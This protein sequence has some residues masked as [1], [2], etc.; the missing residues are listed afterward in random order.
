MFQDNEHFKLLNQHIEAGHAMKGL[1]FTIY[2]DNMRDTAIALF[3]L[4]QN[5]EEQNIKIIKEWA[6]KNI[7]KDIIEYA[8]RLASLHR[9]DDAISDLNAPFVTKPNYFVNSETILKA[10]KIKANNGTI[11]AQER[12]IYQ[13]FMDGDLISINTNFSGW[14]H[15]SEDCIDK[16]DY[17]R[18]DIGLNSY[19]YGIHLLYPFWMSNDEL[20]SIDSNY[21]EEYYYYHR[22]LLA[23][24]EMEKEH[25]KQ[26]NISTDSKCYDDFI[27]YLT[28]EN[29]LLFSTRSSI[30]AEWNDEYTR[31]KS[32]DIAIRECITRGVIFFVSIKW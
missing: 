10:L 27:P 20:S 23:R 25:L 1:T 29:G 3:R 31:I 7:N 24:Y 4:L 32:I 17:F 8:L 12:E 14:N 15:L 6:Y 30:R 28:Y 22:N 5:I 16:L 18:Q 26:R 19:Y 2:D 11:D 9:N 21:A 13:V